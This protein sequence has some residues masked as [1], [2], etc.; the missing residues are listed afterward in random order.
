MRRSK[1]TTIWRHRHYTIRRCSLD[2]HTQNSFGIGYQARDAAG[3]AV[4]T[5]GSVESAKRALDILD[6]LISVPPNLALGVA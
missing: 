2:A 5:R 1:P 3:K 6:G 4:L